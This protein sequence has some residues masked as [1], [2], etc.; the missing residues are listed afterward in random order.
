MTLAQ[1]L[2]MFSAVCA[3]AAIVYF[4]L[5]RQAARW[6]STMARVSKK[7]P[8]TLLERAGGL[9]VLNHDADYFLEWSVDGKHYRIK[10][11]DEASVTFGGF[12][13]WRRV[14]SLKPHK[15]HYSPAKPSRYM[16]AE[17]FGTW[18]TFLVMS[19]AAFIG[20]ILANGA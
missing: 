3:V 11:E 17:D 1:G 12:K 15:L 19:A 6:P 9:F 2:G 8:Q 13:L 5:A 7:E 10:L 16:L 14:P 20:M 4:G 18:K